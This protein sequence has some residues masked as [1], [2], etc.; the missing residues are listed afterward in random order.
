MSPPQHL[1]ATRW[2]VVLAAGGRGE[3]ARAALE[4]LCQ[5]YWEPTH[6]FIRRRAPNPDAALDLTQQFFADVLGR[7]DI[8]RLC[9]E[10]GRFRNW[11]YR[12]IDCALTNDWKY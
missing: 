3:E 5:M 11:L 8:A 1:P 4:M 9:P 2:S 7:R 12:A 6:T 10:K